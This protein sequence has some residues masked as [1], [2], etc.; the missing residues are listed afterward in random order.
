VSGAAIAHAA[1]IA[2][3]AVWW[4]AGNALLLT[5]VLVSGLALLHVYKMRRA[6]LFEAWVNRSAHETPNL[7]RSLAELLLYKIRA[8]QHTHDKSVQR[9]D[10]WNKFYD[11]PAFHDGLDDD[12]KLLES[13]DLGTYGAAA[14]RVMT[15]VFQTISVFRQPAR[16]RGSI[17]SFGDEIRF[18]VSLEN[19]AQGRTRPKVTRVWEAVGALKAAETYP[20]LVE[21]LAY[22]VYLELSGN[23]SF[24]SWQA[25][26]EAERGLQDYLQY[27]DLPA[28]PLTEKSA[29]AHYDKALEIDAG[30]SVCSYNLGVLKYF[31]YQ[32]LQNQQAIDHFRAALHT[33]D[34]RLRGLASSGLTNA[35]SQQHARFDPTD[36]GVLDEAVEHGRKAV[37]LL[38][39]SEIAQKALGFALHQR[40][41]SLAD[42]DPAKVDYRRQAI[43]HY[44]EACR[45]NPRYHLAHNNLGNLYLEWAEP[46]EDDA[47]RLARLGRALADCERAVSIY[48]A[49]FFAYDNIGNIHYAL[50]DLPRAGTA[51]KQALQYKPDYPEAMNDLAMLQLDLGKP[52]DAVRIHRVATGLVQAAQEETR[53]EKLCTAF[54]ARIET[55]TATGRL[56]AG[57]VTYPAESSCRCRAT[58]P[59]RQA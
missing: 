38:A 34:P 19:Y 41:W 9:A 58:E 33:T 1:A 2:R 13:V 15:F 43:A 11:I 20:T 6:V 8:I 27:T 36:D 29:E 57:E 5:A 37:A 14:G 16:L 17:H 25:F 28:N 4:V 26:R 52:A 21:E 39:A 45:L 7:G 50:G 32:A 47:A 12:L 42:S 10:L 22:Q 44:Q 51:Y 18:H 40:G 31:R 59:L 49:F 46:G 56:R 30:N 35:L 54:E 48:P 53:E 55:L 24:K 3:D 23:E